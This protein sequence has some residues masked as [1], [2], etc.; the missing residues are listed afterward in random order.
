MQIVRIQTLHILVLSSTWFYSCNKWDPDKQ[1]ENDI[2]LK[3]QSLVLQEEQSNIA[4]QTEIKNF[5]DYLSKLT[6]KDGE[7]L[8]WSITQV[9]PF[10][11]TAVATL[12]QETWETR[13]YNFESLINARYGYQSEISKFYATNKY[14]ES[15][16]IITNGKRIINPI[17]N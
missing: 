2:I 12:N 16:S 6:A 3:R 7:F 1:F 5:V 13:E 9:I 4:K 14:P 11:V 8:T 17:I 10:K 15:I